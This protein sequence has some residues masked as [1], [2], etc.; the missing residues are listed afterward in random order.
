M[1]TAFYFIGTC[2]ISTGALLGALNATNPFPLFLVAF[3][4]WFLFLRGCN[5]RVR[6]ANER[7]DR[8]RFFEACIREKMRYSKRF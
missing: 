4:I 8:E 5:N 6:K 3:G 2:L 7:R 1:K